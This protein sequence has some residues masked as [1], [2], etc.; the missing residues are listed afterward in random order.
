MLLT[1]IRGCLKR[2]AGNGITRVSALTAQREN[3][4]F[5]PWLRLLRHAL[6]LDMITKSM[7]LY[8]TV[9]TRVFNSIKLEPLII[10]SSTR[11]FTSLK[12]LVK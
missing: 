11:V 12:A 3:R 5:S 9:P 8:S 2:V 4:E 1:P 7:V 6:R 10:Y